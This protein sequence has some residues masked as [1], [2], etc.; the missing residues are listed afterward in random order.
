MQRTV[1]YVLD[2]TG[3][4]RVQFSEAATLAEALEALQT[5]AADPA[6]PALPDLLVDLRNSPPLPESAQLR[7][8]V[9]TL[10]RLAPKLRSTMPRCS[11]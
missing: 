9:A 10:G 5:L 1:S 11:A 7:S 6:M 4:V 3:V 8:I 2:A